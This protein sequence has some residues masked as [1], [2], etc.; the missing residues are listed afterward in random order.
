MNSSI[1]GGA[2]IPSGQITELG[3]DWVADRV[4]CSPAMESKY[5]E[6]EQSSRVYSVE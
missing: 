4:R 5:V 1:T 6:L 3:S 2:P